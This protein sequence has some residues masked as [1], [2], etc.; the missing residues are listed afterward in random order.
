MAGTITQISSVVV[1]GIPQVHALRSDGMLW[2][3]SHSGQANFQSWVQV[4]EVP[5]D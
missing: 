3:L 2:L 1:D 5:Q 4:I